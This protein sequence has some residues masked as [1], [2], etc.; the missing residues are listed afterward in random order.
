MP[1]PPAL[2]AGSNVE[3]HSCQYPTG[4]AERVSSP[5]GAGPETRIAAAA[6]TLRAASVCDVVYSLALELAC[7][8]VYVY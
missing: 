2:A 7:R 6:E 5:E 8:S 1:K 3:R 4:A